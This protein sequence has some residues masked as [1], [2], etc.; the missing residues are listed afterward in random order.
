MEIREKVA[1]SNLPSID[2]IRTEAI[3]KKYGDLQG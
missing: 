1:E 2:E 3:E